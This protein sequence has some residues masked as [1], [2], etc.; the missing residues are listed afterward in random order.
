MNILLFQIAIFF[1]TFL[2]SYLGKR[3]LIITF[4]LISVFTIAMVKTF[5]LMILQFFTIIYIFSFCFRRIERNQKEIIKSHALKYPKK[6]TIKRKKSKIKLI[7]GIIISLIIVVSVIF[8]LYR[9]I[10]FVFDIDDGFMIF[11]AILNSLLF[12]TIAYIIIE[13]AYYGVIESISELFNKK[14]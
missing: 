11:L 13:F 3:P 4:L 14:K 2:A 9:W 10:F 5:P 6:L 1:V 7:I 8:G 12:G